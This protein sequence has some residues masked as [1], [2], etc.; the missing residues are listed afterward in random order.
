MSKLLT[1][2][3]RTLRTLAGKDLPTERELVV[4]T[5]TLGTG[6]GAHAICPTGLGPDTV[7]YSF[8]VG[9]DVSFD[10]ALI[11]RWGVTVHAF[12]P[13]PRSIAWVTGQ[14]LPDRFV[15]HPVGVA[16]RD[17]DVPFSPPK[18]PTHVSHS[19]LEEAPTRDRAITVPVRRL[20]TL[21][22]ELG[23]GR[24]DVLKMDVEGAEYGVIDDLLASGLRPDQLLVEFH[25]QLPHVGPEPTR[26]AVRA[27]RTAGYRIFAVS[28]SGHGVSF[29]L[30]EPARAHGAPPLKIWMDPIELSQLTAI[31]ESTQPRRV[32]EW[33]CGGSTATLLAQSPFIER[34]VSVEHNAEWAAKVRSIVTDPRLQLHLAAPDVPPPAGATP[35]QLGDWD[36]HAEHDPALLATYVGL[37]ATLG[38]QFDLILVDGR[39]RCLCMTAGWDLLAPGGVLLVHDAQRPEYHAALRRLG[40]SVFLTPWRQGQLCLVRKPG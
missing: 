5:E 40:R 28:E 31:L 38:L 9:E 19:L 35:Q 15:I 23:H 22:T 16:D 8:G 34:Y 3:R 37:P 2:A 21:M 12:D 30:A 10:L 27:L 39:A 1:R 20:T 29:I 18:D 32:L 13:T 36:N 11:E 17:G 25:H 14:S 26:R 7:V 24:V 33:G 4:P 6:S